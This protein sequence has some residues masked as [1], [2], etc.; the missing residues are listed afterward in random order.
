MSSSRRFVRIRRWLPLS[1]DRGDAVILVVLAV[2]LMTLIPISLFTTSLAQL[3]VAQGNQ[4]YQRALAAAEAGVADYIN[5]LNQSSLS[6]SSNYWQYNANNLPPGGN[7]AFTGWQPVQGTTGEY[8]HYSVDASVA[9]SQGTVYLTSTGL[10]AHGTG[11]VYRTVKVGLR[12]LGFLDYLLLT[13]TMMISPYFAPYTVRNHGGQPMSAAIAQKYC[14][15]QWDQPNPYSPTGYGPDL[16]TTGPDGHYYQYGYCSQLINYYV[17]G[18]V[19]NG[20][21]FTN[22]IYYLNGTPNFNGHAYSAS[23][24]TSGAATHPYWTDP[25]CGGYC[26]GDAPQA[27]Y[28]GDPSYHSP[29][30]FPS[31]NTALQQ[32]AKTGGCL[33]EGPTYI[34]ISGTTMK[35]TSP[36]TPTSGFTNPGC[37]GSGTLNLPANGVI[38]V[39]NLPS[40][41]SCSGNVVLENENLPCAQ[42]DALLQGTLTG[43]LTV[44]ADNNEYIVGNLLYTGCAAVGSTDALGLVSNNFVYISAHFGTTNTTTDVCTSHA[45]N[46]PVI[47]AAVLTLN[48][49]FA[50]E[51][52][53]NTGQKNLGTIYFTGSMAGQYADIEGTFDANT[54]Q[55]TNGY[56]TNYTYDTRLQYLT[57]P[58]YL[59]PV[60]S[61][62]K[63]I[64]FAEITDPSGL[65]TAP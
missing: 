47:Y 17:T 13:N 6:Q 10:S 5:R 60:A 24:R 16:S 27:T 64:T 46:N 23:S 30:A 39:E 51:N 29:L 58:Y 37:L 53:F 56:L 45:L 57:P 62:W 43:Q 18:Q 65:P 21:V 59:S 41:T 40:G 32:A 20:D 8:F 31:Q 2:M 11:S 22:D 35:V 52:F 44:G 3:P 63:T 36:E 49:S 26:G 28:S 4:D 61:Q 19:F 38:Y 9:Q 7:T 1:S 48:Q 12:T 50:V 55:L 42:G 54:G 25:I 33:Y 14:A 34:Q 15:Y